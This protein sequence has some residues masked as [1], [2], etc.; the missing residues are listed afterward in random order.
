MQIQAS[1]QDDTGCDDGGSNGGKRTCF[2]VLTTEG[3]EVGAATFLTT[4]GRWGRGA[5]VWFR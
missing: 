5:W 4:V 1:G 3:E 2:A